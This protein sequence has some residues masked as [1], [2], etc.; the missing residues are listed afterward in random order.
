MTTPPTVG[1][2]AGPLR[3]EDVEHLRLLAIF[4]YVVAGLQAL[5]AC[6]PII[7]LTIGLGLLLAPR[8]TGVGVEN[9]QALVGTMFVAMASVFILLGWSLAA[10][11]FVAGR[12]LA[13]RR[14]YMFCFVVAAV[15]AVLCM[16]FGTILGVLT[17]IVLLRPSV[18]AA[19]G[20][21]A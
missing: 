10:C 17:I 11:V 2:D 9:P 14:R 5:F 3:P 12:S 6:I 7:H 16:P 8:K 4:H 15:I 20:R 13:A 18:K 1:T 19:F 21:P